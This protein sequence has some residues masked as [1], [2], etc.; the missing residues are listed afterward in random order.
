M[1]FNLSIAQ[2]TKL[3]SS[4][5]FPLSASSPQD[6]VA[7][8]DESSTSSIHT[9][10]SFSSGILESPVLNRKGQAT[11]EIPVLEPLSA[12]KSSN[13]GSNLLQ[14]PTILLEIPS[15]INK[16]LSPIREMPTP[17]PS[18]MPS[19]A[20]TPL[21]HRSTASS[22]INDISIDSNDDRM[23]IEI[24]NISISDEDDM[25]CIQDISID[26]HAEDGLIQEEVAAMHQSTQ[27]PQFRIKV[28]V[29]DQ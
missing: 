22:S 21:M 20:V 12:H 18:P 3:L 28:S 7:G 25:H 5:C 29:A 11:I 26:P 15:T 19:P 4:K 17:L 9:P 6:D 13:T 27:S 23:S 8:D 10:I 16:C 24:P 1:S 14:P 2:F